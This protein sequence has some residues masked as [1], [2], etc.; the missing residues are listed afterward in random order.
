MNYE[1]FAES[2]EQAWEDRLP[3]P[4]LPST[5]ALKKGQVRL[6]GGG[7]TGFSAREVLILRVDEREGFSDV[8]LT[9]P[10]PEVATGMDLIVSP[11][12]DRVPYDLVIQTDC[13]GIVWTH[14]IGDLIGV[15]SEAGM[16]SLTDV[17][18]GNFPQRDGYSRGLKLR[19]FFDERLGFK[20]QEG[21]IIALLASD[22]TAQ[23]LGITSPAGQLIEEIEQWLEEENPRI[24]DFDENE[25]DQVESM[26]LQLGLGKGF[27]SNYATARAEMYEPELTL[28]A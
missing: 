5:A 18:Q 23:M 12:V 28:A 14:E 20:E 27:G 11:E 2:F 1:S 16:Q 7:E 13:R 9:H 17:G 3:D 10:F 6:I 25:S 4:E 21:E 19:S 24:E 15:I 22:C 8:L 26:C